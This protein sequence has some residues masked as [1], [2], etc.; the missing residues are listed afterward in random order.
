MEGWVDLGYPAVE[1][2][3]SRSP[4]Q[5]PDHYTT[6]PADKQKPKV[7]VVVISDADEMFV[8]VVMWRPRKAWNGRRTQRPPALLLSEHLRT[9]LRLTRHQP[10]PSLNRRPRR[11]ARWHTT[12]W[13]Q[14]RNQGKSRRTVRQSL[15]HRRTRRLVEVNF[16]P[17]WSSVKKSLKNCSARDMR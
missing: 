2:A 4:V 16:L 11:R 5:R 9:T 6:E 17:P 13:S 10:R 14:R 3:I 1:L 8:H 7:T 12:S 15:E